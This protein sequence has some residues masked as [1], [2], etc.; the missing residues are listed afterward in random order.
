MG[1]ESSSWTKSRFSS[2]FFRVFVPEPQPQRSHLHVIQ[3]TSGSFHSIRLSSVRIFAQLTFLNPKAFESISEWGGA[4]SLILGRL[5]FFRW[6][7]VELFC[8]KHETLSALLRHSERW[9]LRSYGSIKDHSRVHHGC[10]AGAALACVDV[11][12]GAALFQ[13]RE[14][15]VLQNL[16]ENRVCGTVSRVLGVVCCG[17]SWW[18]S[19]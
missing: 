6:H 11:L 5:I 4:T 9:R 17:H 10:S 7:S 19:L 18:S 2:I 12:E 16:F 13:R 14:P 15:G 3:Q 8:T 1:R